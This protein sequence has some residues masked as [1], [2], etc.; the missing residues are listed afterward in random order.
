MPARRV[1]A[2]RA[3]CHPNAGFAAQAEPLGDMRRLEDYTDWM[4]DL[5]GYVP[6]GSAE[7]K[8]FAADHD[9]NNVT[10]YGVFSGTHTGE[11]GPMPPTGKSVSSDY[12]YVMEFE[13][14]KI[15]HMTKI[16]NAGWALRE[17]G[18]IT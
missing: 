7:V 14:G 17:V 2:G 15:S 10:A 12:V 4:R 11:G 1:R 9:R 16:W 13:D 5:L 6:D 3:F 8:S 18:W